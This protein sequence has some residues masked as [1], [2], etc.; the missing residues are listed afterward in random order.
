MILC[1]LVWKNIAKFFNK[2][3]FIIISGIFALL[4]GF[5][6]INSTLALNYLIGLFPFFLIGYQFDFEFNF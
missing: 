3:I 4:I 6:D 1:Y 5:I 2:K